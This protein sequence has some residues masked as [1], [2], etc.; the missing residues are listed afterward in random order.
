MKN[1]TK[2]TLSE[3]INA[4]CMTFLRNENYKCFVDAFKGELSK[5]RCLNVR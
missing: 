3:I 4:G 1:I 5:V 2:T